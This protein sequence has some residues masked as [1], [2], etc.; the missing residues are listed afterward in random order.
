MTASKK[1][2]DLLLD[3]VMDAPEPA[4]G[5]GSSSANNSDLLADI[6]GPSSPS[7]GASV[8]TPSSN[9]NIMDLFGSG[10]QSSPVSTPASAPAAAASTISAYSGNGL[11]LGFSA[12]TAQGLTVPITAHFS[13]TGG[14]PIS[15]ISLQAA[16]P[17]TQKLALQ[18]PASQSIG[19]GSTTTQQLRVT[20]QGAGAAVK[21]RVRLGFSVNGQQVQEQFTF[22]KFGQVV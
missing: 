2:V 19:P 3:L 21:L 9:Q 6:L 20:V 18:P 10:A 16:V 1:D 5:G 4:N 14:S 11:S 13:N 22:D 15:S 12:G 7:G 8:A 17:K